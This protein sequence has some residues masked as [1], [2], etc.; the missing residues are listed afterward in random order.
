M[1]STERVT[2]ALRFDAPDRLPLEVHDVPYLY[3]AY[4]TIDPAAVTLPPGELT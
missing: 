3:D 1:T 4:G 2:R